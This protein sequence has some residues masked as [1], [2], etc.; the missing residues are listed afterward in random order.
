M[1]IVTVWLLLGYVICRQLRRACTRKFSHQSTNAACTNS[2]L[3]NYAP[4]HLRRDAGLEYHACLGL[5]FAFWPSTVTARLYLL[6]YM[7]RSP[8]THWGCGIGI[9][10]STRAQSLRLGCRTRRWG[11]G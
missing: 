7:N 5:V 2:W 1:V 6:M 9:S 4:R 11:P 10:V 8:P 3:W